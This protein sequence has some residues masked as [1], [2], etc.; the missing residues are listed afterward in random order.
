ML[1]KFGGALLLALVL[2]VQA[3]PSSNDGSG[4]TGAQFVHLPKVFFF[5]AESY[6]VI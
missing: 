5:V 3:A 2:A 1:V 4:I 6:D